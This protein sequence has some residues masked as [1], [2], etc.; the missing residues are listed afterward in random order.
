[1]T[2]E[3]ANEYICV[4]ENH[5]EQRVMSAAII[6]ATA[7]VNQSGS[8]ESL[9]AKMSR[10][11]TSQVSVWQPSPSNGLIWFLFSPSDVLSVQSSSILLHWSGLSPP[12]RSLCFATRERFSQ[13]GE[14]DGLLYAIVIDNCQSMPLFK[15]PTRIEIST[16][17]QQVQDARRVGRAEFSEDMSDH[18]LNE[19]YE[20]DDQD[21]GDGDD[22]EF[23]SGLS[24]WWR[25]QSSTKSP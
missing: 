15:D 8:Y 7:A 6:Q 20:D 17:K 1:M 9:V 21:N 11:G 23:K 2:I 25:D 19:S 13:L 16:F 12:S 24:S 10:G 4:A 18:D 5:P 14:Q 3:K 22:N